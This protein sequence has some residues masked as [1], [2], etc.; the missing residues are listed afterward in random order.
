MRAVD[1]I[2]YLAQSIVFVVAIEPLVAAVDGQTVRILVSRAQV[3]VSVADI[4]RAR[5]ETRETRSGAVRDGDAMEND[6]LEKK[7]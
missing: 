2:I 1:D 6:R 3:K 5:G 4:E 7:G